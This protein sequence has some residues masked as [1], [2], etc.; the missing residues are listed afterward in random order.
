MF[1]F[2]YKMTFC[3]YIECICLYVVGILYDILLFLVLNAWNHFLAVVSWFTLLNFLHWLCSLR[4][5]FIPQVYP[6]V[7]SRFVITLQGSH[8]NLEGLRVPSIAPHQMILCRER[9]L[10]IYIKSQRDQKVTDISRHLYVG[11][12]LMS[13]W[14]TALT[15]HA[16]PLLS[17]KVPSL[18]AVYIA[19]PLVCSET[20]NLHQNLFVLLKHSSTL[21]GSTFSVFS[22]YMASRFVLLYCLKTCNTLFYLTDFS[23]F[24]LQHNYCTM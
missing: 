8:I 13:P 5:C 10:R 20:R 19:L 22:L 23:G 3:Y 4:V 7:Y 18:T 9:L 14:V 21:D 12:S 1:L 2:T 16:P 11:V 15:V 17:T 6:G 24:V